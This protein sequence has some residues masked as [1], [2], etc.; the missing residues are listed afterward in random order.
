MAKQHTELLIIGGGPGGYSAAFRAAALGRQV[1]IVEERETLGGVCLNVGCIPSKTLLHLAE[2]LESAKVVSAHGIEFSKPD[3][4][5]DAIRA[6]KD[7][8]VHTLRK[9]L[10]SLVK[11]HKVS[12][13][14]GRARF[15]DTQEVDVSG[16]SRLGFDQCILASGSRPIAIPGFPTEH[17]ALWNSTDALRLDSI[18]EQL[19]IIGGGVIGLEMA[20]VY[21]ALGSSVTIVEMLDQIVP[22]ADKDAATLLKRVLERRG[23]SFHLGTKVEAVEAAADLLRARFAGTEQEFGAVLVAVGRRPNTDDLGLEAAAVRVNEK[24]LIETD[25]CMR[26]N[27]P[28]IFAVGDITASGIQLAHKAEHEGKVAAEVAAGRKSAFI[29]STIPSVAYTSPEL[30]WTGLTEKE[31]KAQ[32][33][34][35][36][37]GKTYWKAS[38]R[39][40]SQDATDGV[41]KLLFD[42]E[43]GRLIGATILG[44]GAG[45]LISEA[46]LA[47]EMG[48]DAE[49]M[50]RTIHPHP[51]LS[52]TLMQAAEGTPVS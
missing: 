50:A 14:R 7:T 46:T 33:R 18:P 38:G 47:L 48:A 51:T 34:E 31:V 30:A 8:V 35:Y 27:Q 36:L 45:E 4:K 42:K 49:D 25:E 17:P 23:I 19:L 5:L 6:H 40:L 24:G 1:T 52:E 12:V 21:N 3:I 39:A 10:D 2:V 11:R 16:E 43:N 41:T 20:T 32:G 9:G 29:A 26:S 22:A 44:A 15:V 37:V 28:H 13:I